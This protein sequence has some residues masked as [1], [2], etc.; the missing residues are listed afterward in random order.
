M[1]DDEISRT[2]ALI[3][4]QPALVNMTAKANPGRITYEWTED[5]DRSRNIRN[6]PEINRNEVE[7]YNGFLH[8]RVFSNDGVLNMTK[9]LRKDAGF[10]TI[11]ASNDEGVSHTKIRID[12]LYQP[13]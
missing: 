5:N 13:R 1:F 3:E 6:F 12:V 7:N 4:G 11:K 2:L 9:V 8:E 10:Y